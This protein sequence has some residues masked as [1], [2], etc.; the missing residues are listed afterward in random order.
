MEIMNKDILGELNHILTDELTNMRYIIWTGKEVY[1]RNTANDI[2]K[3]FYSH[4][5]R[6]NK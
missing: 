3:K 5:L 4:S 1:K 6:V 2:D